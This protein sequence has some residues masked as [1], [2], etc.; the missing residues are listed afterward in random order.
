[1][2]RVE[3]IILMVK[4]K[5]SMLR[6]SLC[7]YCDVYILVSRTITITRTGADDAAKWLDE[8]NKGVV[9]KNCAPF[10]DGISEIHN[11]QIDNAK[12]T[13]VVMPMYNLIEY[14]NNYLKTSGCLW[15]YDRDD[16]NDDITQ[17]ESYTFKIKI[18]GK[19]PAAGNTKNVEVA[20]PLKWLSNFWRT[21]MKCH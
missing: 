16:W 9:L 11:T 4:F 20:V 7:G 3:C 19:D 6:S 21:K 2:T 5:T 17:S 10:T 15:Q 8:R 1:M 13:D 18:T 14:N 12:Y